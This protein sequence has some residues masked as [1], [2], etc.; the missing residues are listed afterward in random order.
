METRYKV[1]V[2][3]NSYTLNMY[4]TTSSCLVNGKETKTFI[5]KHLS[6]IINVIEVRLIENGISLDEIN[7]FMRNILTKA[8][9]DKQE[10]ITIDVDDEIQCN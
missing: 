9:I 7:G 5:E 4:H 8:D 1:A 3:E 6:S 10:I 2:G